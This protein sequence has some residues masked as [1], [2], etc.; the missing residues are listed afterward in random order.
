[1]SSVL[2]AALESHPTNIT[3]ELVTESDLGLDTL[4]TN[5]E[6]RQVSDELARN[7]EAVVLLEE[8]E[9]ITKN[10]EED[11]E[12]DEQVV[13]MQR[14]LLNQAKGLLGEP[15][16]EVVSVESFLECQA[17]FMRI[18]LEASETKKGTLQRIIEAIARWAK[19]F[20]NWLTGKNKSLAKEQKEAEKAVDNMQKAVAEATKVTGDQGK[21]IT[22]MQKEQ[23]ENA[24][25]VASVL[26]AIEEAN[27]RTLKKYDDG[28]KKLAQME[29]SLK[30]GESLTPEQQK[31]VLDMVVKEGEEIRTIA[32]SNLPKINNPVEL[33]AFMKGNV[34]PF[35]SKLRPVLKRPLMGPVV[36]KDS[37]KPFSKNES[38]ARAKFSL[39]Q[40]M[41]KYI[42]VLNN[43][44]SEGY[45]KI[46]ASM[47]R[48]TNVRETTGVEKTKE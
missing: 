2:R 37:D 48:I 33:D 28:L 29:A 13:A 30:E 32:A 5:D 1:M 16:T 15:S 44:Y 26:E 38:V 22:E 41:A 8:M 12:I 11:G 46:T 19:A 25:V 43:R 9:L 35:V 45:R 14:G 23:A 18:S 31:E 24:L 34:N 20:W 39:D 4:G 27:K 7:Q 36:I 17:E 21:K 42:Q 47:E 3:T 10:I 6:F 40:E